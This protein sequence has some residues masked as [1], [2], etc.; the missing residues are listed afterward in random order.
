MWF[1]AWSSRSRVTTCSRNDD[2]EDIWK[3]FEK[4][5]RLGKPLEPPKTNECPLKRDYFS[6]E[7]IFQ[8]HWFLGDI[9]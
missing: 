8:S 7:Y 3:D 2:K 4:N 6:R 9:R 1:F 5:F